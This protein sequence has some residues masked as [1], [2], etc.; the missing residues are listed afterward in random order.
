MKSDLKISFA[1]HHPS[2]VKVSVPIKRVWETL[3]DNNRIRNFY[4]AMSKTAR[5]LRRVNELST[6]ALSVYDAIK[7]PYST[8][9]VELRE[10]E[11]LERESA[12]APSGGIPSDSEGK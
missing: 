10:L 11:A 12:A 3:R 4:R 9:G 8:L 6:Y 2:G 1:I 7:S 5:L